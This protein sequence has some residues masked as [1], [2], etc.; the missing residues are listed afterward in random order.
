MLN[1]AEFRDHLVNDLIPF[2][3]GLYDNEYGGFYGSVSSDNIVNKNAP[4][5]AVLQT[6]ILWFYSSCYKALKDP[7]LLELANRQFDFIIKRMIDPSDGGIYWIVN[8]DGTVKDNRKHPYASAFALY[9]V[10]AY[11]SASKNESALAAAEK[12]FNHIEINFK[13]DYGYFDSFSIGGTLRT[14]NT[15]LHI[16]E[17]YTEYYSAVNTEEAHAGLK[18]ALEL[19]KNKAYSDELCRIDCNFGNLME[20]VG[21]VLSYGHDIEASWLIYRA[22]ET[23]GDIN[24][25][26]D[27]STKLEKVARNVIAKGFAD[28][29]KNGLYYDCKDGADNKTRSWWVMSEAVIALVHRWKLYNDPQSMILAVNVWNYTKENFIS[30]YGEWYGTRRDNGELVKDSN[31]LCGAWK[32]PYHNGRMCLELMKML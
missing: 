6:R 14:M 1:K 2:W 7:E 27:L 28:E 26:S 21:N 31:G 12:L 24:I 15:L 13:D 30:P 9:A 3:N 19:V 16:T 4:K 8:H 11:Y 29:G 5:S 18:Y 20:P 17:A 22:C 23:L 32:C 10:S 25:I